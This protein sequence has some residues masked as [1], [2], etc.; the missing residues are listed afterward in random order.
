[1]GQGDCGCCSAR[2]RGWRILRPTP[3]ILRL[4]FHQ[5]AQTP[6]GGFICSRAI[7]ASHEVNGS[8]S[9]MQVELERIFEADAAT[10]WLKSTLDLESMRLGNT[11]HIKFNRGCFV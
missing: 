5:A 2:E 9:F 7:K 1:M 10:G 4:T 8:K 3:C 6:S 11:R